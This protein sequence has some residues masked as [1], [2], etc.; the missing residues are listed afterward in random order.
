MA[1]AVAADGATAEAPFDSGS[2][3]NSGSSRRVVAAGSR[4]AARGGRLPEARGLL[5]F[6]GC[7]WPAL[8]LFR[9]AGP[10]RAGSRSFDR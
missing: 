1:G 3:P 9:Q 10:A 6:L 2:E 7:C 8:R 5:Q 4:K